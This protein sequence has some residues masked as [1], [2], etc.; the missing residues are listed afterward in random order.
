V[1][2][3]RTNRAVVENRFGSR[4][5]LVIIWIGGALRKQILAHSIW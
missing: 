5:L 1:L 3:L 2:Q 4:A